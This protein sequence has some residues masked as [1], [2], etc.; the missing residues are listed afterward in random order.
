MEWF[1]ALNDLNEYA[2]DLFLFQVVLFLLVSRNFLVQV[3]IICILHHDAERLG[4]FIDES[5]VVGTNT[6]VANGGENS[7]L[8]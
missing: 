6:L 8:I 1:Q 3:P 7:N 2:P 4:T 5:L